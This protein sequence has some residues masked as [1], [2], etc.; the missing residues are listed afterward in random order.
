MNDDAR[1]GVVTAVLNSADHRQL[2]DEAGQFDWFYCIA[3]DET[4]DAAIAAHNAWL[5]EQA[6]SYEFSDAL[7]EF[8][9]TVTQD[10]EEVVTFALTYLL[11]PKPEEAPNDHE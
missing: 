8:M 4:A 2:E 1:K 11:G 3:P 7:Q 5:W 6:D 9:Q 10:P